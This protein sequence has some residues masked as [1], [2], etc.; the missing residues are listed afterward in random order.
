[1]LGMILFAFMQWETNADICA[2]SGN[3]PQQHINACAFWDFQQADAELN[4]VWAQ[5][6]GYAETTLGY[7]PE[8]DERASAAARLRSAQRAWITVR[9]EHC[10]VVSYHMRGGSGESM[11]YNGCRASMT[12]ARTAELRG[13]MLEE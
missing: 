10:A 13:M 7:A 8:N 11:L 2:D 4:G 6:I 3:L 9:D 1:M 12:Q 5:A